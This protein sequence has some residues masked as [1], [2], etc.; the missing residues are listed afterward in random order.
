MTGKRNVRPRYSPLKKGAEVILKRDE[1]MANGSILLKKGT[2]G[3]VI[4]PTN[5]APYVAIEV[6]TLKNGAEGFE[7]A[8]S[9]IRLAPYRKPEAKPQPYEASAKA[10][11]DIIAILYKLGEDDRHRVLKSVESYFQELPKN[12]WER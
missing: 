2:K 12:E 5:I 6:F 8:R 1:K 7:V 9:N 11:A 10:L 4:S 3:K